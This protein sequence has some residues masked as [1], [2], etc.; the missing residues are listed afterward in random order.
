M[1][2]LELKKGEMELQHSNRKFEDDLAQKQHQ[3]EMEK[4]KAKNS[5]ALDLQKLNSSMAESLAKLGNDEE[6]DD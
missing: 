5:H 4:M 2:E 3:R 1:K 6:D